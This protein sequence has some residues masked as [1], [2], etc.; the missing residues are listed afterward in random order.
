M[1]TKINFLILFGIAFIFISLLTP[2]KAKALPACW[3]EITNLQA[4]PSSPFAPGQGFECRVTVSQRETYGD[5]ASVH[6]GITLE[7]MSTWVSGCSWKGWDGNAVLFDCNAPSTEGSYSLMGYEFETYC[8]AAA[9]FQKISVGTANQSPNGHFDGVDCNNFWGWTKD[10]DKIGAIDVNF[11]L[12]GPMGSGNSIG[13]I[14][15]NQY[16][17]DLCNHWGNG[18]SDC[19]HGF[20]FSTP[21]ILK[22]GKSHSI[23]AYGIDDK[24]GQNSLLVGSPITINCGS[25]SCTDCKVEDT[26]RNRIS[27]NCTVEDAKDYDITQLGDSIDDYWCTYNEHDGC[28]YVKSRIQL[29]NGQQN[30]DFWEGESCGYDASG[31]SSILYGEKKVYI[32]DVSKY[33][34]KAN[35]NIDD[36]SWAW[37]NGVEVP[38]LHKGC[39]GWSGLQEVTNYF[40]TGWNL[41]KFR[42]DDTCSGARY[43]NL[44]WDV[45]LKTAQPTPV[46]APNVNLK[47]NGSD[48]PITIAYNAAATISWTSTNSTSCT[49]SNGWSG[50]KGTSGSE[51]T[52]NLTSSKTYTITCTGAG[53]SA[54]DSITVNV[55]AKPAFNVSLEAIPSSG[56]VPLIVTFKVTISGGGQEP[57]NYKFDCT[58]DGNWDVSANEIYDNIY[59]TSNICTFST[60]GTYTA[61]VRAQKGTFSAE[62]TTLIT[63]SSASPVCSQL[64]YPKNQWQRIWYDYPSGNCLGNAPDEY[65]EQFDNIWN[66][67]VLAFGKSEKVQFKSSRKINFTSTGIYRFTVGSDDG[68]RFWIDNVLKIDKWMDRGY[69]TDSVEANLSAGEHNFRLDY[70][71]SG[72]SARASFSFS[73]VSSAPTLP[74]IVTNAATDIQQNQAL[75]NG[76]LANLGGTSSCNVWIEWGTTA[77]Y[78]N[79]SSP[80]AKSTTGNFSQIIYNLSSQTTYHFRT[81]AQNSAGTSYG[82]DITFTTKSEAT[83]PGTT[84]QVPLLIVKFFPSAGGRLK[85]QRGTLNDNLEGA[86]VQSMKDKVIRLNSEVINALKGGSTYYGY[87]DSSA[88]PSLNYYV[89]DTREFETDLPLKP[90]NRDGRPWITDYGAIL[91]NLNICDYVNNKDIKEVWLW[92]YS[93]KIDGI[94]YV[95]WESNMAGPYGDISNSNRDPNDMPICN[96]TYTL[97]HYNYGRGTSEATEDHIHQIESVFTDVDYNLF[98]NKFVGYS[99]KNYGSGAGYTCNQADSSNFHRCGNCHFPPNGTKDY[100]WANRNYV[101]SDC[102]DWNPNGSGQKTC[103]NCTK[104]NCDS[105]QYFIWWMQNFPGK[106]NTL[107]YE[108]RKLKN[109]WAFI[110]DF[111]RAMAEG[112]SLSQSSSVSALSTDLNA[113]GKTD[114]QDYNIALEKWGTSGVSSA[115]LN[116]DG[117]VDAK[118][119]EIIRRKVQETQ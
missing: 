67:D 60:A 49:A 45:S 61:R 39:C 83:T 23:Y 119:L 21:D 90:Y 5:Y 115:D 36:E 16:R 43:F 26:C 96:K 79:Q 94:D 54:T 8:D 41:I 99:Y 77:A 88:T 70:Y 34:I 69:I 89:L 37:I 14:T 51:S 24:G 19:N 32:D 57:S 56:N 66:T 30:P 74:N 95:G 28:Q 113:D 86:S 58:N 63:V 81:V 27:K 46:P 76:N 118:D 20:S 6:C 104:W 1:N 105:L 98:L 55:E 106:N 109:F 42:A 22:D 71:E 84:Y 48:G 52:G 101:W 82:N 31:S 12:D 91:N 108:N 47:A 87:K 29:V 3:F 13:S 7:N 111:D 72:G 102:E 38:G 112:R 97:Y 25:I 100:D 114:N 59:T 10:P 68:V 4:T 17:Q 65:N 15:A 85:L 92:S 11:Y 53:G 9:K 40:N 80:I 44:D 117:V 33:N 78:G 18:N 2:Q 110:G 50:A 103:F 75:L 73:P 35:V 116:S 107:Y 64:E 62:T 93:A